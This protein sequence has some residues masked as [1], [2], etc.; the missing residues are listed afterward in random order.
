MRESFA[1]AT[2]TTKT[3]ETNEATHDAFAVAMC[4][5]PR[6][7]ADA[8]RACEAAARRAEAAEAAAA[9]AARDTG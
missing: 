6:L 7:R 2:K 4:R 8:T 3:A 1:A 5:H 9:A